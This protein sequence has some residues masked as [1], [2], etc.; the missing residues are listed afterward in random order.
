MKECKNCKH[1]ILNVD[2]PRISRCSSKH[3]RMT[4]DYAGDIMLMA[5]EGRLPNNA[6]GPKGNLFE[7]RV[8]K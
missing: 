8:Y 1:Y 5:T 7:A 3:P 6:C 2:K 4:L